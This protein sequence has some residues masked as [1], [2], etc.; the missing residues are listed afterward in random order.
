[1]KVRSTSVDGVEVEMVATN[2][3][4]IIYHAR[5]PWAD[6]DKLELERHGWDTLTPAT[7]HRCSRARC[8]TCRKVVK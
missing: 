1:M 8:A 4:G 2:P 3:P 6:L 7:G 5:I